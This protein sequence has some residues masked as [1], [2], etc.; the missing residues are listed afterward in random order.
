MSRKRKPPY[1]SIPLDHAEEVF[2][3]VQLE[4]EVKS[5]LTTPWWRFGWNPRV[6]WKGSSSTYNWRYIRKWDFSYPVFGGSIRG[7]L[8]LTLSGN[9]VA[10]VSCQGFSTRIAIGNSRDELIKKAKSSFNEDFE[11]ATHE[12]E[13]LMKKIFDGVTAS[14]KVYEV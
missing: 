14:H 2:T 3:K 10:T 8:Y 1:T 5:Q 9:W 4:N 13:K 11:D 6:T 12:I 7:K